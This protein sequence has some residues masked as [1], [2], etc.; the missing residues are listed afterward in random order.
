MVVLGKM[1]DKYYTYPSGIGITVHA[2]SVL[3]YAKG[4]RFVIMYYKTF[5]RTFPY[6]RS[7]VEALTIF[8]YDEEGGLFIKRKWWAVTMLPKGA[9]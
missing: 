9:F 1:R 2:S 6:P 5:E 3:N 4:E 8:S 7:S